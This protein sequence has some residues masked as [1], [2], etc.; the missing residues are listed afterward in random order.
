MGVVLGSLASMAML[1]S[2][3]PVAHS[4]RRYRV[5]PLPLL[6]N[7]SGQAWR[8]LPAATW[9][10]R[11][12]PSVEA[13]PRPSVATPAAARRVYAGTYWTQQ[14]TNGGK[15]RR[16]RTGYRLSLPD[17]RAHRASLHAHLHMLLFERRRSS[18]AACRRRGDTTV[19]GGG[20]SSCC[21]DQKAA[22]APGGSSSGGGL[23]CPVLPTDHHRSPAAVFQTVGQSALVSNVV[24]VLPPPT[25]TTHHRVCHALPFV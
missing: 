4:Y 11:S 2:F 17:S 20:C 3:P 13:V 21:S 8:N 12:A 25:P 6:R 14:D 16:Q 18:L 23:W 9:Q 15:R 24:L 1:S 22:G 5:I 10:Q 19:T 7:T